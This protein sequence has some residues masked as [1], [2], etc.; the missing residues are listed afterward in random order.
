MMTMPPRQIALTLLCAAQ[1]LSLHPACA[2]T[3]DKPNAQTGSVVVNRPWIT[4]DDYPASAL[5]RR[6]EGTST[7]RWTITKEG[8]VANCR[9]VKSSGHADLDQ[10]TCQ[11]IT[12]RGR[13][14]PQTDANGNP[15]DVEDQRSIRWTL[16][17]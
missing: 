11:A 2:Q 17:Q 3:G 1:L 16:P 8:F 15:V 7:V 14:R 5:A 6:A 9:V 12:L 4:L 13:Y 10:A